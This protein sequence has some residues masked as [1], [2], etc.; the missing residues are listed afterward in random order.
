MSAYRQFD[1]S[2]IVAPRSIG[3]PSLFKNISCDRQIPHSFKT[4]TAVAA[5]MLLAPTAFAGPVGGSVVEGSAGIS[6]TGST[7]NINQSSGKAIIDWQGFSVGAKETV[8]FNQPNGSSVTL[9]RVVGNESSVISGALNANGQVFIVNS[10]GVLFSKGSQVNVGGLVASTRDISNADFMAGNYTFSGTSSGSVINQG[11][12]QAHQG[13]YIALL[14][15]TVSN[16]GV[17][18][19]RL[20]TVAMAAGDKITLNFGGNSLLDVTID[21]GTLNALVEN[22]RAIRAD[23]GQVIMTAKAADQVLSA[24]V[25]NS[26]IVQARTVSALKG[27]SNGGGSVHIGKIKLVADGGTTNVSGKL[28]ASAPKGGNGGLIET[29]GDH[30]QVADNAVITTKS[31]T[32]KNGTWLID[33][34]DFNIVSGSGAQTASGIGATTLANNLANGD[35]VITTASSGSGNG[36]INVNANVS[37]FADTI[38]TLNAANNININAAIT[39]TGTNAGLV[40]NFGGYSVATPTAL[41]GTDYNINMASGGVVTLSGSNASLAINGT[42]YTL[43]HTLDQLAALSPLSSLDQANFVIS[44]PASGHYALAQNLNPVSDPT[45][46]YNLSGPA[47]AALTGTLT[48]LGHSISGLVIHENPTLANFYSNNF[49]D[50]ALTGLIGVVGSAD[51][52]FTIVPT[53]VVRDIG[54]IN[55][56]V[57]A[58]SGLGAALVGQN[59]GTVSNAYVKDSTITGGGIYVGGLVGQNGGTNFTTFQPVVA[60]VSN[61]SASNVTVSGV[62]AVGGLVGSNNQKSLVTGSSATGINVSGKQWVGGLVGNSVGNIDNSYASGAV[63]SSFA[64]ASSIGGLAG[65]FGGTLSALTNSHANVT[66]SVTNSGNSIGG[67]VGSVGAQAKVTNSYADGSVTVSNGF[68]VG[69]LIGN[70]NG[71]LI[72]DSH[73]TG[74]VS[75]NAA[76]SGGTGIGGLIGANTGNTPINRSYATGTVTVTGAAAGTCADCGVGGLVGTNGGGSN[77]TDSYATGDVMAANST[78]VG[79]LVGKGGAA[80]I[81]NSYATGNVTGKSAVGGLVGNFFGTS[82][83]G[84]NGGLI[85]GSHA[86]GN[87]TA[88]DPSVGNAGGLVGINGSGTSATTTITNSYAT[89]NVTGS[90]NV[91]GFV[92]LNDIGGAIDHSQAYGNVTGTKDGGV[93]GGFG[94]LDRSNSSVTH[95]QAFGN[96]NGKGGNVGAFFGLASRFTIFDGDGAFGE[97]NGAPG[98]FFGINNVDGPNV[99][100]ITYRDLKAEAR[101]AAADKAAAQRANAAV[102]TAN[103]VASNA[104]ALGSSATDPASASSAGSAA[105]SNPNARG[106]DGDLKTVDEKVRAEEVRERRRIASSSRHTRP[107]EGTGRKGGGLGATIRSID[108]DGQRFD[109]ENN[110]TKKGAGQ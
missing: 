90:S 83:P 42:P 6:Q 88:T 8:N 41:P 10:A 48:G 103:A 29:S 93:V 43:I 18:S 57:T 69:G 101:K 68:L 62:S 78:D 98:T 65:S 46:N 33:P 56:N 24:Q 95:S 82:F 94:G 67:L 73:A 97:V 66:V 37:C 92:G 44:T 70:N 32:G 54:I 61:S 102:R 71:Y 91:G 76:T 64:N 7:T 100:D 28:D 4:M 11:H 14:G 55:A 77:I 2:P 96:V 53:A 26:G 45:S 35:V 40:L 72:K 74:A 52:G 87:V 84:N 16:E 13:G 104:A 31:A 63:S 59:L 3:R 105:A 49:G 15:K 107:A 20:G 109:L 12:I 47:I 22:K 86:T 81:T 38:L 36:D 17:I 99:I 58:T 9:N 110:A 106:I 51:F 27:G 34:T 5:L 50:G 39:A 21:K 1:A 75:V 108:V 60:T 79:G 89:G 80:T 25:N 19:A 85:Q 30:V 23:G